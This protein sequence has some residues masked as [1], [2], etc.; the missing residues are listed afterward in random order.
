M[1][2]N[3]LAL[4]IWGA[5]ASTGLA[6][7][8]LEKQC[9]EINVFLETEKAVEVC[10]AAIAEHQ[11][12]EKILGKL[13]YQ[14]AEALYRADVQS[15]DVLAEIEKAL[16]IEPK[17]HAYR[18]LKAWTLSHLQDPQNAYREL[19]D[20]I[21]DDPKNKEAFFALGALYSNNDQLDLA[22]PALLQAIDIDP[23]FLKP[24]LTLAIDYQQS[25]QYEKAL[26]QLD[27][28]LSKDEAVLK[29][30]PYQKPKPFS[31]RL[32][33][34]D[35]VAFI[36]V[37]ILLKTDRAKEAVELID[38]VVR[39]NPANPLAL[40]TQGEVLLRIKQFGNAL[41]IANKAYEIDKNFPVRHHHGLSVALLALY[42]LKKYDEA[43]ATA[44]Q[45]QAV[46]DN[47]PWFGDAAYYKARSQKALGRHDEAYKSFV[48]AS[49]NG[50]YWAGQ[51]L[52][53]LQHSD[54]WWGAPPAAFEA[55]V[56]NALQACAIDP[57]CSL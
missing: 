23:D 12:D 4:A 55:K 37:E 38:S 22:Q 24:R 39:N 49:Q 44:N 29:N 21:A 41:V 46:A 32:G 13:H 2:G 31:E 56:Y 5:L 6:S 26:E 25:G 52:R 1:R 17:N 30:T 14:L 54:Y 35:R 27:Y 19:V 3:F 20:V 9:T 15:A 33:F 47:A 45:I 11:G 10:Q 36:K 16:A 8:A 18:V 50:E 48:E 51:M 7:P 34:R 40:Q 43:I 53:S 57:E 28:I 42:E